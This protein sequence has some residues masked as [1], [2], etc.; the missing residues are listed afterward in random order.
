MRIKQLHKIRKRSFVTIYASLK[1]EKT[2]FSRY[3]KEFN[4]FNFSNITGNLEVLF[5]PSDTTPRV[6]SSMLKRKL[7]RL[8]LKVKPIKYTHPTKYLKSSN[9][10]ILRSS[11]KVKYNSY[12]LIAVK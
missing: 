3:G 12:T 7:V 6:E 1:K 9:I 2:L 11:F 10:Q 4:I 8:K 5:Y